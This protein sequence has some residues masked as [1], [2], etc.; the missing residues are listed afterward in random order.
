MIKVRPPHGWSA[1]IWELVIVVVGVLVA[2]WAGQ[3][4]QNWE[5]KTKVAAAQESMRSELLSDNGPQIY[6]R[7]VMHPCAQAKLDDIRAAVEGGKSRNEI[8]QLISGYWLQFLTYDTLALDAATASDVL[9]HMPKQKLDALVDAYAVIPSMDRNGDKEEDN[10]A[11]LRSLRRTGGPLSQ[12]EAAEVVAAVEA[13]R[14]NDDAMW[15]AARWALP[16]IQKLGRLD[17]ER[18]GRLVG[19]ARRHYGACIRD[20]PADWP[21]GVPLAGD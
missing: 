15:A 4:V 17:V 3:L 1:V 6:Q 14:N 7:A 8:S 13:L 19:N 16:A 2:L 11:R 20:L 10:M 21:K 12:Q 9:A 5:W 18:R